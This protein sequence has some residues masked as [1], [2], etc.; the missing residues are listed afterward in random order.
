MKYLMDVRE[1]VLGRTGTRPQD[2]LTLEDVIHEDL[3]PNIRLRS[4]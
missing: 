4:H 3:I 2:K 1:R